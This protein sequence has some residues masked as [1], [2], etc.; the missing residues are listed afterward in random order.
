MGESALVTEL[1]GTSLLP[2]LAQLGL[3]FL[4]EGWLLV[5]VLVIVAAL[6][7]RL[8]DESWHKNFWAGLHVDRRYKL[9]R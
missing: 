6:V 7:N 8:R 1:A 5:R 2:E 4:L 9:V 3:L